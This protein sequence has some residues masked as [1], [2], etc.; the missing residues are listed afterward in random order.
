[1][2]HLLSDM[3]NSVTLISQSQVSGCCCP[4][5]TV[6]F[7]MLPSH[8]FNLPQWL[9]DWSAV[10]GVWCRVHITEPC[11]PAVAEIAT[12]F[13]RSLLHDQSPA[14]PC[15]LAVWMQCGRRST[16]CSSGSPRCCLSGPG[17]LVGLAA[18]FCMRMCVCLG[19][20]HT[21]LRLPAFCAGAA[22]PYTIYFESLLQHYVEPVKGEA[23]V[24]GYADA[25]AMALWVTNWL[26]SQNGS[27]VSASVGAFPE[28]STAA[29]GTEHSASNHLRPSS[30]APQ[31]LKLACYLARWCPHQ[32]SRCCH[33]C[34]RVL[35]PGM[36]T[37]NVM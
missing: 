14:L 12:G 7:S 21:Q 20:C 36:L 32:C 17:M 22:M 4:L 23:P 19:L 8:S 28:F 30:A 1:M 33:L 35:Q 24:R 27:A 3:T 26:S 29:A 13:Q 15:T 9:L 25:T 10:S 34:R 18:R 37:L 5:S 16:H 2:V 6:S 11:S 31:H